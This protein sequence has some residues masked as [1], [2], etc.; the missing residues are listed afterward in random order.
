[1]PVS[2][3]IGGGE[4]P[5]FVPHMP[6]LALER[7]QLKEALREQRKTRR[8]QYRA[9]VGTGLRAIVDPLS[10]RHSQ[11]SSNSD[12]LL[13]ITASHCPCV[14]SYLP[15]KNPRLIL[16]RVNNRSSAIDLALVALI[17]NSP[18]GTH[19]NSILSYTRDSPGYVSD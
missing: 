18:A 2:P 9:G 11:Y 13:P 16:T 6:R 3:D 10:A 8:D 14:T 17:R 7:D 5:P 4:S 1:M 19:M 12:G 15:K